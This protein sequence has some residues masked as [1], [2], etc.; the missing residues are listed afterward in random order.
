MRIAVDL[1]SLQTEQSRNR[2]IGF[3]THELVRTTLALDGTNEYLLLWNANLPEPDLLKALPNTGRWQSVKLESPVGRNIFSPGHYDRDEEFRHRSYVESVLLERDVDLI[4]VTSPFEWDAYTPVDYRTIPV[5]ATV[6]D[7]I[8]L[9][10]REQYLDRMSVS[11]RERYFATCGKLTTADRFVTISQSAKDD[12]CRH[13][14]VAPDRIDVVYAS[15]RDC[16]VRTKDEQRLAK[17]RG[18]FRLNDGF[19]LCPAGIDHR[20]N[21]ERVIES[22]SLLPKSLRDRYRLV[23]VCRIQPHEEQQLR[24]V[25]ASFGIA[26]RL[27]V[28]GYVSDETLAL[29]YSAADV[30]LFP[31]LYEGFGLPVLEAQRC[32]AAVITSETSSLPEVAGDAALLVDPYS[33]QEIAKATEAVLT[34]DQLRSE[35]RRRA[36][37]QAAKFSAEEVARGTIAAYEKAHAST[38]QGAAKIR[39][40]GKRR[41]AFFSPLNPQ[42]SGISDYSEDLLPLLSEHLEIDLYVDGY[43]LANPAIASRFPAFDYRQFEA[44]EAIRN[45]DSIIYQMGNSSFHEY[46]YQT[47]MKHPGVVV[48]HDVVLHGLIRH[49]TVDRGRNDRF[50]EEMEFC[51]GEEGRCEAKRIIAEGLT[52]EKRYGIALNKRVVSAARGVVTHSEWARDEVRKHGLEVPVVTIRQ[53]VESIDGGRLPE[54]RRRALMR[55][56]GIPPFCPFVVASF[57]HIAV[58]KRPEVVVKAF[59]R[60]LHT[61]PEAFLLFIGELHL[62]ELRDLIANLGVEASVRITGFVDAATTGRHYLDYLRIVDTFVNLRFPTAGETSA[63]V[64]RVMSLGKPQIVSNLN[65]FRE[66]PDECCWKLDLD[67]FEEDTL[68]AYL[69]ELA[70][71]APLRQVMGENSRHYVQKYHT[72]AQAAG[73]YVD[74]LESVLATRRAD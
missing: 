66:I 21:V 8:P 71:N 7:L 5:V 17:V 52:L 25:A 9:V 49:I 72:L 35:L 26:G 11:M 42:K 22:F 20:K 34:D 56:V 47:L 12:I 39:N 36:P 62:Q 63:A 44:L 2:G 15:A 65:Q 58:T 14:G 69:Q 6:F 10:F 33:A 61:V 73:G 4:H 31:S 32:G 46:I 45:Y 54:I 74:F 18:H 70:R 57:G 19:V 28:T 38:T 3:F 27:V 60:L 53:G 29:L 23:L 37:L 68:V 30:V 67:A 24:A 40:S 55:E 50:I 48:L 41:V 43:A 64:L 59:A 51:Y 13:L 1:H 16:F